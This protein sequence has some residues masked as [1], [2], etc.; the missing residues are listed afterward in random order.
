M[1]KCKKYRRERYVKNGKAREHQ[2]YLSKEFGCNFI[3]GDRRTKEKI[4]ARK[5]MCVMLLCH[6]KN[7]DKQNSEN[8]QYV[9]VVRIQVDKRSS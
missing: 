3:E 7:V 6:R 1:I 2:K 9:L 8:I 5:V 4:Q